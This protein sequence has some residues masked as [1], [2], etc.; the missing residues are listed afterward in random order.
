MAAGRSQKGFGSGEK[1]HLLT[2]L[3]APHVNVQVALYAG[4]A[5]G[6]TRRTGGSNP[7]SPH[8]IALDRLPGLYFI[9][10][11]SVLFRGGK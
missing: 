10:F 8:G 5:V 9:T 3:S 2:A 4:G 1:G 7:A 11:S 6:G